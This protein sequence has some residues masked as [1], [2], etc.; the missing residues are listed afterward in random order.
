MQGAKEIQKNKKQVGILKLQ[1]DLALLGYDCGKKQGKL[2]KKT[3]E[4]IKK[5][6]KDNNIKNPDGNV[7]AAVLR[8]V[9]EKVRKK[10]KKLNILSSVPELTLVSDVTTKVDGTGIYGSSKAKKESK[11]SKKSKKKK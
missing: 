4:A 9:D 7:T 3:R 10:L 6:S 1:V 11:E 8:K 5:F 2:N